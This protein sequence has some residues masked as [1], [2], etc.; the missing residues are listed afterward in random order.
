MRPARPASRARANSPR[1]ASVVPAACMA[2][3]L[4]LAGCSDSNGGNG[5]GT[6]AP[7]ATTTTAPEY[8]FTG[9]GSTEFCQFISAFDEG[10]QGASG[11][12]DVEGS[13]REAQTAIDS[14][15]NVAPAEIKDSVVTIAEGFRSMNTAMAS[16]G[17]DV[18][19]LDPAALNALQAPPFVAAVDRMEAYLSNVCRTG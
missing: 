3:L 15:V 6:A 5:G 18:N 2:A 16:A 14:A 8:T 19:R 9:E 10:S 17:F 4:P 13:L 1:R 11:G 12:A 7:A